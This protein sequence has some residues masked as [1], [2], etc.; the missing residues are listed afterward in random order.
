MG[1]ED[2][3]HLAVL[4][5]GH[6]D[7]HLGKVLEAEVLEVVEPLNLGEIRG[8]EITL[9]EDLHVLLVESLR[10][11]VLLIELESGKEHRVVLHVKELIVVRLQDIGQDGGR[12]RRVFVNLASN[13]SLAKSIRVDSSD[14]D[15]LGRRVGVHL[16]ATSRGHGCHLGN[17]FVV[18][19]KAIRG[20]LELLAEKGLDQ[21]VGVDVE[22]PV[23]LRTRG[24]GRE[25]KVTHVDS[26]E[27]WEKDFESNCC[28]E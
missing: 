7:L 8:H 28:N 1:V 16:V 18:G 27:C 15:V 6:L 3:V 17:L 20:L 21:G 19:L 4:H 9:L 12:G 26:S 24:R 5:A 13:E 2:E 23:V 25:T 11:A 14:V 22:G 10:L